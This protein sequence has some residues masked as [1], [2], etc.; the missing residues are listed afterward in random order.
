MNGKSVN[1]PSPTRAGRAQATRRRI[2]DAAA[3]LF[4]ERGYAA[5]AITEIAERAGTAVQT[6]YFHFGN[7][8]AL[9]KE[10]VDIAA[11]GDDAP[12]AV[13]E[14]PWMDRLRD[15]TDPV[16][17]LEIWVREGSAIFVRIAPIMRVV[18]EAAATEPDMAEQWRINEEQR[19]TAFAMLAE[20]LADHGALRAGLT[21]T[22]ATDLVFALNSLEVYTLLTSSRGWSTEQWEDWL[23]Q[24]LISSLLESRA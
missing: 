17:T 24:A 11:A 5:T 18:R 3:S 10:A 20:T 8:R 14:R 7:K 9:V 1:G 22:E 21:S 12:V 16:R 19:L 13:L 15:E 6:V 2:I 23:L 4:I